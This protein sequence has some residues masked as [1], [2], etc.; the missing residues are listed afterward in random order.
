MDTR[1]YPFSANLRDFHLRL[2]A[3]P[4][5]EIV[6]S[7]VF[8]RDYDGLPEHAPFDIDVMVNQSELKQCRTL[9]ETTAQEAN[10][11]CITRELPLGLHILILDLVV[12][13]TQR[14]WVYYEIATEKKLTSSFVLTS[15]AITIQRDSGLPLPDAQWQFL[16]NFA[17]AL[18]KADLERYRPILES[19]LASDPRCIDFCASQLSLDPAEI[20]GVLLDPG[21]LDDCCSRI[22]ATRKVRQQ[23]TKLRLRTKWRRAAL[24][25][26]YFL[27]TRHMY[28]FTIHGPDGVGKTTAC[29]LVREM[30]AGY[31][32]GMNSAHHV[33][34]WKRRNAQIA[35]AS[36]AATDVSVI[37]RWL[38]VIYRAAP[39]FAR[40]L[41]VTS[42]GYHKYSRNVN[43]ETYRSYIDWKILLLDR[44]IYDVFVK[45]KILR[46]TSPLRDVVSQV[47]CFI[48]RRPRL[49]ILLQDNPR[50]IVKRKQELNETEI[51]NYQT[52]MRG[53]VRRLG[54]RF[55]LINVG[56][57]SRDHIARDVASAII[58]RVGVDLHV[59]MHHETERFTQTSQPAINE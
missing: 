49:A 37:H 27:P 26:L 8:V 22:G 40:D 35:G 20:H 51:E 55:K 47:H 45:E 25:Y 43:A 38:R 41:W 46:A 54:V 7:C 6:A 15:Q 32:I 5:H 24:R 53:L 42:S 33:T 9:F 19:A 30:F 1:D 39:Q 10:L 44:Y 13:P 48:M 29:D 56:G 50:E 21:R 4:W 3:T 2:A 34:S 58:E 52:L 11:V 14:T 23:P 59:L 16:I 18:R 31:P 12:A 57:R 28:T 17:Q 36:D